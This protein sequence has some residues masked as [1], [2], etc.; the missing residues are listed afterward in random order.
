METE[1][2]METETA[3]ETETK[4]KP[5]PETETE[6]ET[7]KRTKYSRTFPAHVRIFGRIRRDM[8]PGVQKETNNVCKPN[9]AAPLKING[10]VVAIPHIFVGFRTKQ[11][12]SHSIQH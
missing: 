11:H 10:R 8:K 1:K 7:N 12:T 3:M 5:K 9:F 2:E 6:T 4:P